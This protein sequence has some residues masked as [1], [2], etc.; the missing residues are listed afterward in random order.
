MGNDNAGSVFHDLMHGTLYGLFRPC[1][2][3]GS[4]FVKNKDLG[5]G[6]IYPDDGNKLSLSLAYVVNPLIIKV[7]NK[8]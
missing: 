5:V 1:I 7:P 8:I 3:I 4:R 2:Y 6:Y